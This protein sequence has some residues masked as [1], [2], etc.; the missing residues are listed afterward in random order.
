MADIGGRRTQLYRQLI[1]LMLDKEAVLRE[2]P[3]CAM[4]QYQKRQPLPALKASATVAVSGDQEDWGPMF[5]AVLQTLFSQLRSDTI[6]VVKRYAIEMAGRHGLP[7]T[8]TYAFTQWV[9][10]GKTMSINRVPLTQLQQLFNYV[11]V[12]LCECIGPIMAD[13][14]I[15]HAVNVECALTPSLNARRLLG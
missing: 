11:Y 1:A 15:S 8:L 7:S 5:T 3:F 6:L 14:L 13:R 9:D 10:Q 4:Q 2:D 12:A